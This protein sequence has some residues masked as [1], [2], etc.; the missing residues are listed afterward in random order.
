MGIQIFVEGNPSRNHGFG[1][2]PVLLYKKSEINVPDEAGDQGGGKE[3]MEETA[4]EDKIPPLAKQGKRQEIAQGFPKN[5]TS[6]D[7]GEDVPGD[8]PMKKDLP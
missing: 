4:I 8:G 7:Q 3:S 6:Q 5:E 1:F 2:D